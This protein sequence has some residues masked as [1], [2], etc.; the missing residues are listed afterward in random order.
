[1][2]VS[3]VPGVNVTWSPLSAKLSGSQS[4]PVKGTTA[5]A[6][7]KLVTSVPA[8]SGAR[9]AVY[10]ITR[11]SP[12]PNWGMSQAMIGKSEPGGAPMLSPVGSNRQTPV[13]PEID[14]AVG[15]FCNAAGRR[16]PANTSTVPG[17]S[18]WTVTV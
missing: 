4:R 14:I 9:V 10:V 17:P 1:M 16:S 15:G 6:V 18:L 12:G 3:T 13:P 8:L 2:P 11:S 7:A 5:P